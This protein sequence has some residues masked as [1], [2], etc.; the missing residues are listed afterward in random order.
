MAKRQ[1]NLICCGKASIDEVFNAMDNAGSKFMTVQGQRIKARSARYRLF[2]EK[3]TVCVCCGLKAT[4]FRI[5][6]FP[7]DKTF[8]LNL[9]A[10]D[11]VGHEVLF[12]KD[13]I[14]PRAHGGPDKLDNYQTMCMPCN[15]RKGDN[16]EI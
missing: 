2:K 3:G 1:A 6:R 12:T 15:A 13:H 5:E 4:Y 9:Y 11:G 10:I 16:A 7:A 8:H 14:I